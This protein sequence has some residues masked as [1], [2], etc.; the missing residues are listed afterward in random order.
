MTAP[1]TSEQRVM[2]QKIK[3]LS[4]IAIIENNL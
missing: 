1:L 3:T 4:K 2:I